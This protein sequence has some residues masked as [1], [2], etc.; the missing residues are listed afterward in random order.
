MSIFINILNVIMV[1]CLLRYF[2][3]ITSK[4]VQIVSF[5]TKKTCFVTF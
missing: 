5:A 1:S 4:S 2:T 3:I